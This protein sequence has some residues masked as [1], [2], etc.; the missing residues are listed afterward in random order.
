MFKRNFATLFLLVLLAASVFATVTVATPTVLKTYTADKNYMV[1][2]IDINALATGGN[3]DLNSD[4]KCWY[5]VSTGG[6]VFAATWITDS[7]KC[8]LAG[9]TSAGTDD[10]NFY[11]V[12]QNGAK[13]ANATSN[14][15]YYWLDSTAPVTVGTAT[16]S[17]VTLTSI[18]AATTTGN[19]SG[20]KRVYYKLDD[21]N[22]TS[23]TSNPVTL[24]PS[25]G[26]HT[27]LF[28]ATDNLDNNEWV[29]NGDYWSKPF[30]TGAVG[31][32][33]CSMLG[34]IVLVLSAII[35]LF[36]LIFGFNAQLDA[37]LI[38][39]LIGAAITGVIG[40]VILGS[41]LFPFCGA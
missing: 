36:L 3:G 2:P 12:V 18:D 17:T 1:F 6:G 32:T 8:T 10:F 16:Y 34:T 14:P 39:F 11:M 30:Y 21:A 22:W 7:N 13:D 41:I 20:V 28:Y 5:M 19:G 24:S 33:P 37:K 4:S 9:Y 25:V 40:V 26:N 27:I 38:L 23:T 15:A 31:D 29:A 35:V